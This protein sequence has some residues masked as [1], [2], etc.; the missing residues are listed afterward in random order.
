MA[1]YKLQILK[2]FKKGNWK[3]RYLLAVIDANKSSDYP[4]NF[5]CILPRKIYDTDKPF[6]LF[7]KKFGDNSVNYV[8]ELLKEA[9]KQE[10]DRQ[11]KLN[12]NRNSSILSID[13]AIRA[14]Y[15]LFSFLKLNS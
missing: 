4:A 3:D 1:Y 10:K 15:G 2:P 5:V 7:A 9:I 12:Y 11:S 13:G 6:S 14:S 8:V